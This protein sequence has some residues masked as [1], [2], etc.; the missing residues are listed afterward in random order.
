[1]GLFCIFKQEESRL[2][3]KIANKAEFIFVLNLIGKLWVSICRR[4]WCFWPAG[5]ICLLS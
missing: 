5:K 3:V 1:M 2:A 4:W